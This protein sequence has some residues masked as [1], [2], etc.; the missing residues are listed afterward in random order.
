MKIGIEEV[1]SSPA[2][3]NDENVKTGG[4]EKTSDFS[5]KQQKPRYKSTTRE[6]PITQYEDIVLCL[7]NNY[8]QKII[9]RNL[10][11]RCTGLESHIM[12]RLLRMDKSIGFKTLK[13]NLK[14]KTGGMFFSARQEPSETI[15]ISM[16]SGVP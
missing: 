8:N 16:R 9:M 6:L 1:S 2:A 10:E 15:K 5:S 11:M 3:F 14:I 7:H 4:F 12:A 13:R